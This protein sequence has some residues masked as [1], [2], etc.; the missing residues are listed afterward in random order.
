MFLVISSYVK[1]DIW[2]IETYK[3]HQ[4]LLV[5]ITPKL[6]ERKLT[7]LIGSFISITFDDDKINKSEEKKTF[8]ISNKIVI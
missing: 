8:I 2:A 6:R 1:K 4:I 5:Y 3:R 7:F